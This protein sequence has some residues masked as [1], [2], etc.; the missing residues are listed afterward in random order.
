M[1][2]KGF[3]I[4]ELIIAMSLFGMLFSLIFSAAG[5]ILRTLNTIDKDVELQQQAQFIF[6]FMEDKIVESA[7]VSYL[8]DNKGFQ[9]HDT[10]DKVC[11]GKIIFKNLPDRKDKGY[12][13]SL[14]KDPEYDY[15]NLKYGVG[16]YGGAS[17][18]AGNYISSMEVEP[19]PSDKVYTESEGIV[20]RINF[21]LEGHSLACENSYHYRNSSGGI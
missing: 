6:S 10:N 9:K 4:I 3:T 7:G 19:I 8:S 20:L 16:L 5:F 21:V 14:S 1:K 17:D 15:F 18:E 11:L 2:S 13:F 12:I